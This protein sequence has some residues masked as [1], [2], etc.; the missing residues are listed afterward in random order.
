[1]TALL[2]L[3]AVL[4]ALQSVAALVHPNMKCTCDGGKVWAK[5]GKH[6]HVHGRC[7]G[8]GHIRRFRWWK[9]F[10]GRKLS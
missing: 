2:G 9:P 4:V 3:V 10:A 5:D 7:A 8:K 1:M 6:W